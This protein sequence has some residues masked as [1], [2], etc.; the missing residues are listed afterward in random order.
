MGFIYFK[1]IIT[2]DTLETIAYTQNNQQHNCPKNGIV[3]CVKLLESET[4]LKMINSDFHDISFDFEGSLIRVSDLGYEYSSTVELAFNLY[5]KK[6]GNRLTK[7]LADSIKDK[8]SKSIFNKYN[9]RNYKQK[10]AELV[11]D[12]KQLLAEFIPNRNKYYQYK[13]DDSTI[14]WDLVYRKGSIT[15]NGKSINCLL[16]PIDLK[17]FLAKTYGIKYGDVDIIKIYSGYKDNI[18]KIGLAMAPDT[19]GLFKDEI[20]FANTDI[21]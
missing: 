11:E 15:N 13:K 12:G 5:S 20:D 9:R 18:F 4:I 7:N 10:T 16:I 1:K 19:P 6:E 14:N 21:V 8:K 3:Y 17:Y 2:Y